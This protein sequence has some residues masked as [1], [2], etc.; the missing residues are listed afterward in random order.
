M[1]A[2]LMQTT[3][4]RNPAIFFYSNCP[5]IEVAGFVKSIGSEVDEELK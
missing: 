5:R 2:L 1:L 4:G 3:F